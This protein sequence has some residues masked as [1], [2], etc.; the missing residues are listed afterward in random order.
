[1]K[2]CCICGKKFTEIGNN[3]WPAKNSGRCCDKCNWQVVLPE[4]I[5]MHYTNYDLWIKQNN[6]GNTL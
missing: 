4:R 2:T 6:Y 1:M 5:K 3:P